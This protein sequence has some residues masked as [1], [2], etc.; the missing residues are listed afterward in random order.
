MQGDPYIFGCGDGPHLL[1]V[2]SEM[3]DHVITDSPFAEHVDVGNA[4]ERV[5]N[6]GLFGFDPMT[7][8]LRERT[9][10][11]IGKQCRRWCLIFCA[12]EETHLWRD[13]LERYG[14]QS[15][16]T[17]HW[18]K[19]NP[20]PQMTGDRPAQ[21]SEAIV[22]A[23]SP[24]S[25]MRWNGGGKPATWFASVPHGDERYHPTQKPTKLMSELI[26]DFTD[27]GDLVC[28]PFAGVASTGVAA[29]GCDRKFVGYELAEQWHAIG[30]KRLRMPLFSNGDVFSQSDLFPES[31]RV[32]SASTKAILEIDRSVLDLVRASN[33][34][35][36]GNSEICRVTQRNEQEILRSLQRLQRR[37]VVRKQGR[38]SAARYFFQ[39][40]NQ[41]EDQL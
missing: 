32:K 25:A 1:E 18:V 37:G 9:A 30:L 31:A 34:E 11:A 20:K 24:M 23:H 4:A 26:M 7:T 28:D 33:S 19:L 41:G 29:V 5:R 3:V 39:L 14:M 15:I 35:G 12:D 36:I 6:P 21:G 27:P 22:I 8:E 10:R 40:P 38:T 13:V 2:R 17:G 16:R